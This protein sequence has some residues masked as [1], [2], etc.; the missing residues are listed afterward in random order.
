MSEY[1]L[2][3]IIVI[4]AGFLL[5]WVLEARDCGVTEGFFHALLFLAGALVIAAMVV[6]LEFWGIVIIIL[7]MVA[8]VVYALMM[9]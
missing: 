4:V 6:F 7:L 2:A 5:V 1:L 9:D 3:L 8:A